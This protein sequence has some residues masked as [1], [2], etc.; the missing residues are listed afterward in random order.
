LQ[1]LFAGRENRHVGPFIEFLK[2]FQ[3][4]GHIKSINK[5]QWDVFYEFSQAMDDEFTGYS[6]NA[7]WPSLLDDYVEWRKKQSSWFE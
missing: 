1:V 3:S 5:D 7:A 2:D 6:E 4:Q